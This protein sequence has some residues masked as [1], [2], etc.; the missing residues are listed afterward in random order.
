MPEQ[1]LTGA[2]INFGACVGRIHSFRLAHRAS[3]CR[4][5]AVPTNCPTLACSGLESPYLFAS[6]FLLK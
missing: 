6:V 1:N 5:S 4:A 2:Q 3:S